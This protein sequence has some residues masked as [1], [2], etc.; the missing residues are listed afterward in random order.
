[1][2]TRPLP[3]LILLLSCGGR[4]LTDESPVCDG[5]Q[6]A[7]ES[8]VDAPF[9]K[10][11]DGFVDG[12]NPECAANVDP[13]LLDCDD[14]HSSIH[15][16]A[17]EACN[18]VDDNCDGEVDEGLNMELFTDEDDDG[19]GDDATAETD[20]RAN[21]KQ[22][23]LGGDCDD[24]NA[25]AF[26]GNTESCDGVDND[27]NGDVD[28]GWPYSEWYTDVDAD[29]YGDPDAVTSWCAQLSGT[30]SVAGDCDDADA[31]AYPGAEEICD[32]LIDNNCDGDVDEGC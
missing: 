19:Y 10:D 11:D 18:Q 8:R 17:D 14:Q 1:M 22:V 24:A 15:P 7:G 28:D 5:V 32:D 30:V 27:C 25:G 21:S 26:P 4:L 31:T 6:Q 29:G 3:L 23:E 9:D 13:S 20:C 16:G 2:A 12:S